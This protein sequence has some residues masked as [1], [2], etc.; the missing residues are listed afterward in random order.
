MN[1]LWL[2]IPSERERERETESA[3]N[4]VVDKKIT[5][6]QKSHFGEHFTLS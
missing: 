6:L 5:S 3:W 2:R 4:V 1:Q